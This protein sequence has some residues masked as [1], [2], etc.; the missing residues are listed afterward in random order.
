MS[1]PNSL[2]LEL[3]D[4]IASGTSDRRVDALRRVTDLFLH[5][6]SRFGEDI[7]AVFD[8]VIGL[9]AQ[10][11]EARARAELAERLAPVANAPPKVIRTLAHDDTI[12]VARP[13]LT[14]SPRLTEQDLVSVARSKGQEHM[15]ALSERRNIPAAV[16]DVLIDR[17]DAKVVRSVAR[18]GSARLSRS[19]VDKLIRQSQAD[20]EL[21]SVLGGRQ[22]LPADQLAKLVEIA[23]AA[24]RSRMVGSVGS[25]GKEALDLAIE[26]GA[27]EVAVQAKAALVPRKLE[28]ARARIAELVERRPLTEHDVI[29]FAKER[30]REECVCA[31]A[32][33]ANLPLPVAE[34]LFTSDENDLLLIVCRS[35]G[36]SW[37][38]TR[39]LLVVRHGEPMP[40]HLLHALLGNFEELSSQTA[41]R[42]L[43]FLH[44]REA[45][46]SA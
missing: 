1:S 43:R 11:I 27:E 20:E 14:Q 12:A 16:T 15:L 19:G 33:M 26:R 40:N 8:D 9:L 3:Q 38:A 37:S 24:A 39:E 5:D 6:A 32:H 35:L 46:A 23:K 41:Q 44:V 42:V 21:R 28:E 29:A 34:R 13:V 36:F 7:V 10:R 18:N 22:D 17:G 31:L 4:V 45:A 2:V 25:H 30:K